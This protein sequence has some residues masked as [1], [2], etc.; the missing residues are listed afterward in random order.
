MSLLQSMEWDEPSV[1]LHSLN[2]AEHEFKRWG[3]IDFI[4][5]GGSG[6]VLVEVK[7]GDV[8][9]HDG[10]W[11]YVDGFGRSV[12]R[13]ESPL[14]QAKDAYFSLMRS[15][16]ELR[17]DRQLFTNIPTG[18][19]AILAGAQ[20]GT[21]RGLLGGPEFPPA[22]LGTREDLNDKGTL[23]RFFL[24]VLDHWRGRGSKPNGELSVAAVREITAFLRPS[25]DR[26]QP[27]S[28]SVARIRQEQV[29]LTEEQYAC[30]DYWEGAH[31]ILVTGPAGCGKTFVAVELARR[32]A[33]EGQDVLIVTGTPAL[34]RELLKRNLPA[35]VSLVAY[36]DLGQ[37]SGPPRHNILIVDE[38][39]MLLTLEALDRL[40]ASIKGG[41]DGGRWAWFGDPSFQ[42]VVDFSEAALD[43]LRSLA[44]VSPV[45][46]QN[47]RNTPQVV[48][49]VELLSGIPI[50]HAR[51]R[52]NGPR[53]E[54][55][56][57]SSLDECV[58]IAARQVEAWL[59]E[60]LDGSDVVILIGSESEVGLVQSVST[61]LGSPIPLWD[62]LTNSGNVKCRWATVEGFRGLESPYVLLLGIG[63]DLS[64]FSL[65]SLLY[66]GMSRANVGLTVSLSQPVNDRIQQLLRMTNFSLETEGA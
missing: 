58:K 54:F 15:Y 13:R 24:R 1:A 22:L 66:L 19:C 36:K 23:R 5:V 35:S 47:C 10:I 3:E 44:S 63:P 46:R 57:A 42:A 51:V 64:D 27:L 61:L 17:F 12:T 21:I 52:G 55:A 11:R 20:R 28:Q 29:E 37:A 56:P 25:F 30:L 6:I 4:L 40:N 62:G 48:A 9:C 53:V 65:R 38:G 14:A 16:L 18:F 2:L 60:G 7:G 50:G 26:V 49:S 45:L 8:S 34:A 31:R 43:R 59:A 33:M 32:A 41:L 39:Q